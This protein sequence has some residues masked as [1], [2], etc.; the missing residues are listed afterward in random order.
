[1]KPELKQKILNYNRK[2]KETD[3]KANDFQTIIDNLP[4]G[5][6]NNL[7]KDPICGPIIEKY[8]ADDKWSK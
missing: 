1:M 8:Y 7:L 6:I 2:R 3:E 5:Q 4:P